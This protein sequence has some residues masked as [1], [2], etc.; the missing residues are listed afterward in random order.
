MHV[1]LISDPCFPLFLIKMLCMK[2]GS[3]FFFSFFCFYMSNMIHW[4]IFIMFISWDNAIFIIW[5]NH[6]WFCTGAYRWYR[7]LCCLDD[8]SKLNYTRW[9]FSP[10]E[11]IKF[12]SNTAATREPTYIFQQRDRQDNASIVGQTAP[13]QTIIRPSGLSLALWLCNIL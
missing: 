4:N 5:N 11:N 6:L 8:K 9:F 7:D 3:C 1:I 2:R 13:S 12:W 10:D